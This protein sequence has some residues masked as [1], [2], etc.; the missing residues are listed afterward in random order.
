MKNQS[1]IKDHQEEFLK[2]RLLE[3][4][5]QQKLQLGRDEDAVEIAKETY[6]NKRQNALEM[7]SAADAMILSCI[8]TYIE[9]L[10][11]SREY[12][13]VMELI[14]ELDTVGTHLQDGTLW[15]QFLRAQCV[16]D[17][18]VQIRQKLGQIV[19]L[20]NDDELRSF[21]RKSYEKAIN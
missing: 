13:G 12:R 5:T 8:R 2:A 14:H 19:I 11:R 1:R 15:I 4:K 6:E 9:A 16:A 3:W 18:D 21:M 10:Y 7:T 17:M 20:T